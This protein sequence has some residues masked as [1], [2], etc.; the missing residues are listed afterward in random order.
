M[1]PSSSTASFGILEPETQS[2]LRYLFK[3]T[4]LYL[5]PMSAGGSRFLNSQMS[6]ISIILHGRKC[7][8]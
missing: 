1:R 4:Q 5:V 3:V 7:T 8:A 6:I 2:D